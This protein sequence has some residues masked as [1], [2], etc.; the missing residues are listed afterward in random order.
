MATD[1]A[2]L[3]Q[4]NGAKPQAPSAHQLMVGKVISN[5]DGGVIVVIPG[6]DNG[7][8]KWGPCTWPG[9]DLDTGEQVL[10]GFDENGEPWVIGNST[11]EL[12]G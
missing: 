7:R 8:N 9:P 10:I 3:L 12:G 11:T 5:V 2:D 6:F 4:P 1:P